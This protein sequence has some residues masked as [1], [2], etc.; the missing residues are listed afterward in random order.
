MPDYCTLLDI[1]KANG[2]DQ[3]VPLIEEVITYNPELRL[4]GAKTIKG[5]QYKTLV[6]TA[7]PTVNWRSANQGIDPSKEA[8][9]NRLFECF[10]M[11]ARWVCD[12]AVA[13]ANEKG[14]PEL[15]ARAAISQVKAAGLAV[16][17]Q[18]YYGGVGGFPGISNYV[19]SS[20][21]INAGGTT[22]DTGSSL[23]G[24]TF[25]ETAVELV[26]G[27]N[28]AFEVGDVTEQLVADADGKYFLAYVQEFMSWL[29]L[30]CLNKYSVSVIRNLTL[31]SGKNLTDSLLGDLIATYPAG[32]KPDAFFA[33]RRSIN[34]LM[35]S[36]TA[37]NATGAPA[38]WPTEY[39]GIPIY[40]SESIRNN[41]AILAL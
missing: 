13:D 4:L 15:I 3:A 22:A 27:G 16:T 1:V 19:D 37:T 10:I 6:Q 38:P 9:E 20:M 31:D 18:M 14:P 26:V 34:G 39:A 30:Q 11:N 28:G 25:G 32:H 21:I 33:T 12:K 17:Q 2:N 23:W 40:A 8:Y 41:E 7:L 5:T 35:K 36:R 29:G 24:I